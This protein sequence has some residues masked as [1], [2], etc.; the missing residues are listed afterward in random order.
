MKS[1]PIT[2]KE[3]AKV[4]HDINNIWHERFKDEEKCVIRTHSNKKD[5]PSYEYHFIN[6]DFNHYM[7][8]GKY[9][10]IDRR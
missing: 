5:S 4:T 3:A 10:T 6:I 7:F 1:L 2:K 9:P 8:I